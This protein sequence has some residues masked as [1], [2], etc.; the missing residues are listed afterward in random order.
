MTRRASSWLRLLLGTSVVLLA[1]AR[2]AAASPLR[3][4]FSDPDG[5]SAWVAG[6]ARAG[7]LS[8]LQAA[9]VVERGRE[10]F[11]SLT[12][13]I[14]VE[15]DVESGAARFSP[16]KGSP[17]AFPLEDDG[18]L[19]A[20]APE[21]LARLKSVALSMEPLN[22][23]YDGSADS[24]SPDAA[25][26]ASASPRGLAPQPLEFTMSLRGETHWFFKSPEA[27]VQVAQYDG[28]ARVVAAFPG[29]NSG[30]EL[31]FDGAPGVTV[32]GR[33]AERAPQ[34]Q[35]ARFEVAVPAASL[36]LRGVSLDDL[37][38]LR[39]PEEREAARKVRARE[40]L[41]RGLPAEGWAVESA[42]ALSGP[43][44]TVVTW[45]RRDFSGGGPYRAV[46]TFPPSVQVERS[47]QGWRIA[48]PSGGF[49]FSASVEVPFAP[50]TPIPPARLFTPE[51]S[52]FLAAGGPSELA[53]QS[54]KNLEFLLF[55]EKFA[56]GG[57]Q[58]LTYFGRDTQITLM[59][60][61]DILSAEAFEA[62]VQSVLDRLSDRG[63]VA[64][65]EELGS[66]AEVRRLEHGRDPDSRRG[67]ERTYSM[68]DGDFMLPIV[69]AQYVQA[70]SPRRIGAFL[71][72]VN[73]RGETNRVSLLRN[74][75]FVLKK[76]APF[77]RDPRP[78]RLV[79][80]RK[81]GN[82]GNWRDSDD[83]LGGGRYPADVNSTLVPEAL[84]SI[85]TVSAFFPG[86]LPSESKLA[87][88]ETQWSKAAGF[89][90]V[91]LSAAQLR[92]R[93]GDYLREGGLRAE[94]KAVFLEEDVGGG[95]SLKE[96]LDGR[97]PDALK[98]GLT[99]PALS[100]DAKGK[101][102]E[103]E[104]SDAVFPLFLG[105]YSGAEA[106]KILPLFSLPFPLGL[107][108][109][110]GLLTANPALSPNRHHWETLGASDYHGEVAWVWPQMML[111]MGLLPREGAS[112]PARELA[113]RYEKIRSSIGGLAL[114]EV[115]SWQVEGGRLRA[116]P[117]GQR[118][119]SDVDGNPDQL[120]SNIAPA[121]EF[122][123]SRPR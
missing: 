68:V 32:A 12:A 19:R 110:A 118:E 97:T 25:G 59:M 28:P 15:L 54:V 22:L 20:A 119:G 82:V 56:A 5:L 65:E 62:G 75:S 109:D 31:D 69:M 36:L 80:I 34:G 42:S 88:L 67:D 29:G 71:E 121:L 114:N 79:S 123:R 38:L 85:R 26:R 105:R 113:R 17:R 18:T 120:W 4:E 27:A 111:E 47:A 41:R 64:H 89:F 90:A 78:S 2:L 73:A 107:R 24:G 95:A 87:R 50:L 96:F 106:E 92:S 44:G 86:G 21:E 9:R 74:F 33:G 11:S 112:A 23:L 61:K 81:G 100:L 53:S 115:Y 55:K 10:A 7:S 76:A 39:E 99:F 103:V 45:E 72:K 51:F 8:E 98:N 63:Q 57:W 117:L 101:P 102:V 66:L 46:L 49:S 3:G 77:A 14:V 37:H 40:A 116:I 35:R 70:A 83:G 104:N 108:T 16:A 93:V 30:A 1:A 94:E 91:S 13:P 6:L 58:Y 84:K 48:G 60:L 52:R 122:L 43:S